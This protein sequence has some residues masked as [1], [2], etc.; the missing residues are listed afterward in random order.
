MK[1]QT[2]LAI[3]FL[4]KLN[5]SIK[6]F[7]GTVFFP[8]YLQNRQFLPVWI[9]D[10]WKLYWGLMVL[11]CSFKWIT[12][13]LKHLCFCCL[14]LFGFFGFFFFFIVYFEVSSSFCNTLGW[15]QLRNRLP[16]LDSSMFLMLWCLVT[17]CKAFRRGYV[18]CVCLCHQQLQKTPVPP[19]TPKTIPWF[20]WP[21]Y[22]FSFSWCSCIEKTYF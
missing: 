19:C 13:V 14:V 10:W 16:S 17:S 5:F 6:I 7:S 11:P 8:H 22:G 2:N 20:S 1:V 3:I 18:L 15:G 9:P 12:W 4:S 21:I